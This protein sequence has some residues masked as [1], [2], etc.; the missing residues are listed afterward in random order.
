MFTITTICVSRASYNISWEIVSYTILVSY[1]NICIFILFL[2][3]KL[4]VQILLKSIFNNS[5]FACL[6][7]YAI[8]SKAI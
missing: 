4:S 3:H 8:L 7:K 2:I 5:A 6:L 1:L